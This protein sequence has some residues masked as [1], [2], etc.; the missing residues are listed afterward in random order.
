MHLTVSR[1]KIFTVFLFSI[2]LFFAC[3][4]IQTTDIGS[5][6]IPPVDGV[7]TKDTILDV[8]SKNTGFDTVSVGISDD[9]ALGYINDPIFGTTKAIINFQLAPPYTPFSF[10][11]SRDSLFLDSVVLCLSYKGFWGDSVPHLALRVFDMDENTIFR[12]DSSYN[13]LVTFTKGGELTEF[14]IPKQIDIPK[15]NDPDTIATYSEIATSQVR[16]RLNAS[17]GQRLLN[18]D[19]TSFSNDSIF[20][21]RIRGFIVEPEQTGNAL[22]LVNLLDTSTHLSLYYRARNSTGGFDTSSR[23]F[24]PNALTSGSSNTI[25]RNYQGT[26]IPKYFP[27]NSNAQDSLIF[28]QTSPGTYSTLKVPG[29]GSLSNMIV[30]RAEFLMEQVPDNNSMSDTY[31]TAPNLFLAAFSHDSARRI[32]IPYDI[33]FYG[34]TIS[35]LASFG[36]APIPKI[37]KASGKTISSYNFEVTRYVQSI[38]TRQNTVHDFVLWAPYNS[39]IYPI[40]QTI[41]TVPIATPALNAAGI[42]RVRLGGGNNSQHKMRLHIVYSLP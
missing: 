12:S 29:L 33:L 20:N 22:L 8:I 18:F 2:P 21:T 35:N 13:N 36:V 10:G 1:L 37:D 9:H 14:A 4:K 16:I 39:Y 34:N 3:T 23:R 17:F 15:L 31:F 41:Y 40:E 27:P 26:D 19:S 6:L 30:H 42:G 38:V 5:G 25:I 7:N 24:S 32:A 28:I 11:V